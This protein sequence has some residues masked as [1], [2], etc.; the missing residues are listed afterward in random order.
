MFKRTISWKKYRSGITAQ[1]KIN[2]FDYLIDWIFRNIDTLFLLSFKNGNNDPTI[3]YFDK[4]YI[5]IV[6]IKFHCINWQ[7]TIYWSASK[8]NKRLLKNYW[9]D[10]KW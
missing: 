9:N 5:S 7:E 3:Y 4:N 1:Q 10:K 2:N 6:E 8:Q